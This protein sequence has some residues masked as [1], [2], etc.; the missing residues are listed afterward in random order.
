MLACPCV[1]PFS[2]WFQY[3]THVSPCQRICDR[4]RPRGRLVYGHK[5]LQFPCGD[6]IML[7][8]DCLGLGRIQG[9]S[10]TPTHRSFSSRRAW[11]S[12]HPNRQACCLLDRG[13]S[14]GG[15]CVLLQGSAGSSVVLRGA[16]WVCLDPGFNSR[17]TSA[18]TPRFGLS[19]GQEASVCA[20]QWCGDQEMEETATWMN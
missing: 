19:Q 18:I 15:Q 7:L 16:V 17:R 5:R 11:Q 12:F 4:R 20:G 13:S 1:G 3:S 9:V 8:R 14:V 10:G 2:A 6:V